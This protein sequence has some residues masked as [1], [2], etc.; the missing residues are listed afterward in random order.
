VQ[1]YKCNLEDRNQEFSNKI[2][3]G[4]FTNEMIQTSPSR[5]SNYA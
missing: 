1:T 2:I 4:D 3:Y 5:P